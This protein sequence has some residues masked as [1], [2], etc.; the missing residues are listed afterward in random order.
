[1]SIHNVY[2]Y[3]IILI[4]NLFEINSLIKIPLKYYPY[5]KYDNSTPSSIMKGII[6]TKLYASLEL[7]T[8]KQTVEISLQF[9]S[10][11]FFISDDPGYHFGLEP[12]RFSKLKYFYKSSTHSLVTIEQKYLN[13]DNFFFADY[14]KDIFYFENLTN[15]NITTEFEFY[16]PHTLGKVDTGGLGLQLMPFAS[17]TTS[18]PTPQ[19]TF[20]KK[21]KNKNLIDD[22][23]W[24]IFYDNKEN[25]KQDQ[26]FILI[27]NLPDELNID[28]GYYP[29]HYFKEKNKKLINADLSGETVLNKFKVDEIC[30]YKSN[31]KDKI[32]TI[33]FNN[34]NDLN[35]EID[36]NSGGIEAPII[37]QNYLEENFFI[38][39]ISKE[40]CFF[41]SFNITNLKYFFY[42]KKDE[43]VLSNIEKTFPIFKFRSND[44]NY[45]FELSYKDLF[46]EENDYLFC[47]L[48]FDLNSNNNGWIMGK[49]FAKKYQFFFNPDKKSIIFYSLNNE[50]ENENP[51]SNNNILIFIILGGIIFILLIIIGIL[52]WKYLLREKYL[53]KK[54]AN[55]LDD[56]YEYTQKKK[57]ENES[58]E[59]L[60][61]EQND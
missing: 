6:Y 46:I 43:A 29:K 1:M 28:L 30:T 51:N 33:I 4:I 17:N 53:R 9:Y 34:S 58:D 27:G 15:K 10:N 18:T 32:D 61:D 22:Y 59:K 38:E 60:I 16:L 3:I 44:F 56:D 39:Y 35:I 42:C 21:L 12:E 45:T 31:N 41:S 25:N 8:P 13:G 57:N 7:G 54:R 24:S 40:Q 55:E 47:L 23:F 14:D 48:I 36:F 37:L 26:G 52:V 11:D 5:Y 49:P 2:I 19:R 20:L 50:G